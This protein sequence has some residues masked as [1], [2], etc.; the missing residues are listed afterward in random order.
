MKI[1]EHSFEKSVRPEK[2]KSQFE[3][4]KQN[5]KHL[6]F[7]GPEHDLQPKK[8]SVSSNS[9]QFDPPAESDSDKTRLVN[10]IPDEKNMKKKNSVK[11][12]FYFLLFHS[13][14]FLCITF[15]V[16]SSIT[17]D[18]QEVVTVDRSRICSG[19]S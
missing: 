10:P 4:Q 14:C 16:D 5:P 1:V 7:S 19:R 3:K 6:K 17:V 2:N 12:K 9:T 15:L 13:G 18:L 11:L 8:N